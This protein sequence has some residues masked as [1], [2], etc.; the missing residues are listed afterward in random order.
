MLVGLR[1]EALDRI[2]GLGVEVWHR[3]LVLRDVLL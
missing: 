3:D 1:R 2:V